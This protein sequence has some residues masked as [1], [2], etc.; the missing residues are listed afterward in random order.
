MICFLHMDN[1]EKEMSTYEAAFHIDPNLSETDV[2]EAYSAVK[3]LI[4]KSGNIVAESRPKRM[5]LAYTISKM[6]ESGRRD[7]T[8]A[9]FAW[10]AFED[11][12][13]HNAELEE[14]LSSDDRFIRHIVTSTTTE[15]AKHGEQL[16]ILRA[17]EKEKARKE[18][19]E[20]KMEAEEADT[21]DDSEV[22]EE[23]EQS[24]NDSEEE[25]EESEDNDT[26]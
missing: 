25:V 18:Q 2:E 22:A 23:V 16:E 24:E 1:Q 4:S 12:I 17:E 20:K 3:E 26:V 5:D 15:A 13:G 21:E 9:F 11:E 19:E 14:L 8:N 6:E 7:F 10:V